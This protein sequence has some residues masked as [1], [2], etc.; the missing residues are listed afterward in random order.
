MWRFRDHTTSW[1]ENQH[2]QEW[3]LTSVE[4]QTITCYEFWSCDNS[5][6][7][8][9]EVITGSYKQIL[10]ELLEA[11]I[12]EV[13]ISPVFTTRELTDFMHAY[14][15]DENDFALEEVVENYISHNPNFVAV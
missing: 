9:D 13:L 7:K 2:A 5:P 14:D 3:F 11:G 1:A 4:A 8:C 12:Y 6:K 15:E 10:E